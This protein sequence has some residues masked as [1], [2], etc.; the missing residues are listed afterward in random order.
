MPMSVA[1]ASIIMI[2]TLVASRVLGWLRLSV[3]GATF[4]E[5]PQLDAFWA[6]FRI[7]N[8]VFDLLVAGALAS[9]FIPVFTG[10]LAR[11]RE[12]EGWRVAS[13]VLN[14]VVLLLV[15][16]S[17]VM[18][19]LAPILVP[20]VVAPGFSGDQLALT[21]DLTRLMLLSPIFMGLSS[22]TTGILNSYR[23]FLSGATAPLVYNAVII[24]FALFAA[25]FLGIQALAYGVVT[26]AL[27]MWLVQLPELTFRR[28]RYSFSLDLGHPGVR[29][30]LRLAG[31]RT[32]ALG[33]V[34]IVFIVDTNLASRMPEGSLTALTYAFQLMLLPLG[35]FSIAISAAIFPSLSHY[36]SLGQVNRMRDAVQQGIRWILFLTLPTVILMVVLRRPI[37][38]LLFQYGH[39]GAEAREATQAA[40]L[41]YS[42]GLAGHALVQILARAYY[43]SRDTTTPL[44]L[45]LIS[46][47]LN[48]VLDVVLAPLL[49]ING[50]ALANSIATL[51]EALLL[52]WLLASRA[53]LRLV[54]IGFSTLKQVT[55]SLL[56]GVAMFAFIRA[57]NV[58]VDL[59]QT[60]LGLAFQTFIA[61]AV[62]GL[63]YLAAAYLFRI[64]ELGEILAV[65]R[66]RIAR[67]PNASGAG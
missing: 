34:Q 24:L 33:A 45:T 28:T 59:E 50:L 18:W 62:G 53:R 21:V 2:A 40:F 19:L 36:A 61:T 66:A 13:S 51:V 64:G 38:N 37:V 56:M 15:A 27:F 58:T 47:G 63:V 17:A 31:P 35:V 41:F 16:F 55:A 1:R 60:K 52:F 5:S 39:F 8:A 6:A 54:G 26:G 23:Q 20:V 48:V 25:P 44:A 43:A 65:V 32:L 12:E 9:A 22:L 29:D 67:Q 57:T 11:E 7:P 46:I 4:G 3:I 49:G 42:I 14:A 10:Y 30:V